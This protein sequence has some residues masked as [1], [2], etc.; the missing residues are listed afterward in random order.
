MKLRKEY[1]KKEAE[2]LLTECIRYAGSLP[3]LAQATNIYLA[4]LN[5]YHHG[6]SD[7]PKEDVEILHNFRYHKDD[8]IKVKPE[9]DFKRSTSKPP[10]KKT[11]RSKGRPGTALIQKLIA[12]VGN[13]KKLAEATGFTT[14]SISAW[15][16]GANISPDSR[17]KL[18][19]YLKHGAVDRA[20]EPVQ[21]DHIPEVR[22]MVEKEVPSET[23]QPGAFATLKVPD[24]FDIQYFNIKNSKVTIEFNSRNE[25]IEFCYHHLNDHKL[26]LN[27]FELEKEG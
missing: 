9:I 7:I 13:Q 25:A 22:K 19:E 12:M 1:S 17:K 27:G 23:I 3:R 2:V 18:E 15:Y 11:R 14:F 5:S 10:V 16:R 4:T 26:K 20:A 21:E 6:R 24:E 8:Q